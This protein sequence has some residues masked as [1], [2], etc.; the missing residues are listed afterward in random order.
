MGP[1]PLLDQWGQGLGNQ[2]NQPNLNFAPQVGLA[3]D[4]WKSGKTAIRAGAGLY[5][6]NAIFNNVLFDRPG[7]LT[8]GL[9]FGYTDPCPSGNLTLP[10][11]SSVDTSGLCGGRIG[12]AITP[13][14][15]LFRTY[16]SAVAAA[17]ATANPNYLGE[18]MANG[19]NSTGNNF[20]SP[21][22]RT[23]RS[24]QF[25]IGIQRE[26]LP[27][28]LLTVD[29]IRN[30]GTHYLLVYDT[31]HVGDARYL[32]AG[33]ASAAI[34]ATNASF[35]CPDGPGGIDCAIAAGAGIGDYAGNGL[36]SG[37]QA[38]GGPDSGY[39]FPGINPQLAENE[40]LFPIGRSVYN[41][42]QVSVRSNKANPFRGVRNMN[43]IVSYALS[44]FKTQAED[45]DFIT[46][47]PSFANTS[48][49]FGPNALDRTHQLSFG[50]AFN[51]PAAFQL[52]YSAHFATALP[53]TLTMPGGTDPVAL[54]FSDWYGDGSNQG[55]ILPGTNI[56]SF[57]R[58]VKVSDLNNVINNYDK[59]VAGTLTPAGKALVGAGL[60]TQSQLVQLGG[61]LESISPAPADA[62]GNAPTLN[63]S[64]RLAW[65]LRPHLKWNSIPETLTMEPS[66]SVFNLFNFSNWNPLTGEL[67]GGALS[68]NGTTR[69]NRT[70]KV[71]L[72][73]GIFA[74]G[75]PR[76][77]E[78][79][80]K[81]TF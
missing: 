51:F 15:A 37:K 14:L 63:T 52:S 69:G 66:I 81:V 53:A 77:F 46:D 61:A 26:L 28:T 29:Y 23:P 20:I 21:D 42:I 22:Y 45:Q 41:G 71:Y 73:S 72:G 9:F 48:R 3:W 75:A 7:R 65:V 17:G 55:H 35:D 54:F 70:N 60:V 74:I 56:G 30:V 18:T 64:I 58:D 57:G 50:G 79:G 6:E 5:Y 68:V 43:F 38:G 76:T 47:A 40:M 19:A 8:K 25:N 36:D 59:N 49:F 34:N 44:R 80:F 62:V 16:Q 4:P 31:N 32:D 78:W 12:D 33:A 1:L 39:A 27:G 13:A 11:G 24:M 10:D 2:V 67:N